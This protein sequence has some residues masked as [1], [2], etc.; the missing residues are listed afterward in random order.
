[1]DKS[2]QSERQKFTENLLNSFGFSEKEAQRSSQEELQKGVISYEI[3]NS[4]TFCIP[5][6]GKI[7]KEKL[8]EIKVIVQ[9]KL[10]QEELRY[11]AL[12]QSLE[13]EPDQTQEY[14][15]DTLLGMRIGEV[16]KRYSWEVM[17]RY[18]G[19]S[20][21]GDSASLVNSIEKS[22]TIST[23]NPNVYRKMGEYNESV[24]KYRELKKDLVMTN[25]M[26]ENFQDNKTYDLSVEQA[27][28]F[29]F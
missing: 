18:R 17:D 16:P 15:S 10:S 2:V 7:I 3:T 12:R 4:K 24:E 1:M 5:K 20:P 28:I 11:Q 6:S 13:I 29:G 14:Y 19:T 22:P 25:T 27:A 23:E 26:L 9:Q 8:S 21:D